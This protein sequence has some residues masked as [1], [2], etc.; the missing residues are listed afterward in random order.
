MQQRG[1]GHQDP[2]AEPDHGELSSRHEFIGEGTGDPGSAP[3]SATVKTK[4]FSR[5]NHRR[6]MGRYGADPCTAMAD[7][8]N[9]WTR[10]W[11]TNSFSEF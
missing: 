2:P 8:R 1:F 11:T 6:R 10:G 9:G 3:A 5:A 4:R 7:Y